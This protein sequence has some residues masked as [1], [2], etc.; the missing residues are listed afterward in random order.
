[1]RLPRSLSINGELWTVVLKPMAKRGLHGLCNYRKRE[2]IIDVELPLLEREETFL[3]EVMHACWPERWPSTEEKM[4]RR[5]SPRLLDALKSARW[6]KVTRGSICECE[7][8]EPEG[9]T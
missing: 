7:E 2:I 3:H 9:G 5:L 8:S 6:I 4:I 1:M